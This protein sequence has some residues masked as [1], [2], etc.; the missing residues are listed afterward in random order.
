MVNGLPGNMSSEVLNVV[1]QRELPVVPYSLTAENQKEFSYHSKVSNQPITL[2]RPS[3]RASEIE[4]ILQDYPRL[5]AVDYTHPDAVNSNAL[6]YQKYGIPFVMGT[7]GG[8]REQLIQSTVQSNV[9][10]VIAPNMGKQI[11]AL[12]TMLNKMAQSFPG[13]FQNYRLQVT[14][15]HQQ[16]KADTSGTAK[17]MI[18]SFVKMGAHFEYDKDL[19]MIRNPVEQQQELSIP[20]EYI[21]GHAFHTYRLTSPDKSVQIAFQHNVLG[22]NIY[23]QGTVDAVVFLWNKI[24]QKA[25]QKLYN[26]MDVLTEQISNN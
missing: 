26:M 24:Q 17:E 9:Y 8:D 12:Q 19:R 3:Q 16:T 1:L 20:P 25:S 7:T 5:I 18:Q 13:V 2:L 11:V 4:K 21:N 22:R 10:A 6:F 23:A 15:S 14:E